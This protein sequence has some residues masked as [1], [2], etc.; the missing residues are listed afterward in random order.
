MVE[1]CISKV[2]RLW[3]M[4]LMAKSGGKISVHE[5]D[6]ARRIIA[7]ASSVRS[8]WMSGHLPVHGHELGPTL[9]APLSSWMSWDWKFQVSTLWCYTFQKR[10]NNESLANDFR[11]WFEYKSYYKKQNLN[12]PPSGPRPLYDFLSACGFSLSCSSTCGRSPRAKHAIYLPD[13]K[14]IILT[15]FGLGRICR[16]PRPAESQTWTAQPPSFFPFPRRIRQWERGSP[17]QQY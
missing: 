3:P 6:K 15:I 17:H 4:C 16:I 2:L 5:A 11:P 8:A 10:R 12:A 1:L 9:K 13:D 7:L 14:A